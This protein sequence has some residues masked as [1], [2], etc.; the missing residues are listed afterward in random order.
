MQNNNRS[1]HP[2]GGTATAQDLVPKNNKILCSRFTP[3]RMTA[4]FTLI[5]LSIVMV[6]IGLIIGGVL[7]GQ[8][9][10]KAATIRAQIAQIEKYNTAVRTFELKYGYLPGDMPAT[11][12]TAYGFWSGLTGGNDCNGSSAGRRDG[13]GLIEREFSINA[14]Y[15]FVEGEPSLFWSDLA[16]SSS[17]YT[18]AN[19]ID[20]STTS[21][22]SCTASYDFESDASDA[23]APSNFVPSVKIGKKNI[24]YV[25]SANGFN[26]WGIIVPPVSTSPFTTVFS[27]TPSQAYNID[28]KIDDG[29]PTTG[30]VQASYAGFFVKAYCAT[31][32]GS[33]C[34]A[35]PTTYAP[36][37]AL[38]PTK[39]T[40]CY[41]SD[42]NAYS[43]KLYPNNLNCALSFKFQ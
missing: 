25:E 36:T 20:F 27:I 29:N 5:E 23:H 38:E 13:N 37:T 4:A 9:L 28:Q 32:N 33:D 3:H 10:I 24:I 11:A 22:A 34:T 7:T 40:S 17:G 2:V 6:I 31:T 16:G 30:N 18:S 26:Y 39:S 21:K 14:P 35:P 12:A 15:L 19:L 43:T 42:T 41:N 1:L 8:D